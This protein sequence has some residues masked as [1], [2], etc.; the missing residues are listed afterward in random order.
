MEVRFSTDPHSYRK[1]TQEQLRS[2]FLIDSLFQPDAIPMVYSDIDRSITGSVVPVTKRLQLLSSKKEMAAEYFTERREIGII[3]IGG[4]GVVITDGKEHQLGRNDGVY[5]GRGT[6]ELFFV[7]TNA[8]I[9]AEFYFVSYP[10]HKEFPTTIV[11]FADTEA[12]P[13]GSQHESKQTDDL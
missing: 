6:K 10:A 12:S 11:R 8:A 5:I 1:M 2:M 4:E 13:L 7:S 3:N 9:P